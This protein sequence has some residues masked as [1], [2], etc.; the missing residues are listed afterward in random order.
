MMNDDQIPPIN[1]SKWFRV[2]GL[3]VPAM[4]SMGLF[5]DQSWVLTI[6]FGVGGPFKY[7][8]ENRFEDARY[9]LEFL[10]RGAFR[11]TTY[12]AYLN[13]MEAKWKRYRRETDVQISNAF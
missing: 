12:L 4:I 3:G 5:V 10:L 11:K 1:F 9:H 7:L 2:E 13:Y 8:G 6:E